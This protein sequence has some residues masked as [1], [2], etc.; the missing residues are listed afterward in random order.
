M[1]VKKKAHAKHKSASKTHKFHKAEKKHVSVEEASEEKETPKVVVPQ[2]ETLAAESKPEL[3]KEP[4]VSVA[5]PVVMS[6]G[7]VGDDSKKEPK[8]QSDTQNPDILPSK[9]EDQ[10]SEGSLSNSPPSSLSSQQTPAVTSTSGMEASQDST[11][12][13]GVIREKSGQ[14]SE[15]QSVNMDEPKKKKLWIIIAVV[16]LVLILA[17]GALWYFRENVLKQVFAPDKLTPTPTQAVPT[18]ATDSAQIELDLSEYSIKVLN[19][20]GIAGE[21]A[22]V[23]GILEDEEFSVEEIGNADTADYEGTVIQAKEDVSEEFLDKL[24]ELLEEEFILDASEELEESEDVD[25]GII[26]GSDKQL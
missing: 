16:V 21:A 25:V 4:L 19:G 1:A 26:V 18:P 10:K 20:S 17:G 22:R 2:P 7:V 8:A 13:S 14:E 15:P 5:S 6:A 11:F 12:S 9:P 24:K 3:T 23:Q